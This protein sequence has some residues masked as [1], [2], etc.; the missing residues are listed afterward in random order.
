MSEIIINIMLYIT[1]LIVMYTVKQYRHFCLSL[2]IFNSAQ[3]LSLIRERE[4]C[5]RWS[6][7]VLLTVH[8]G[9]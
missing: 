4:V 9:H 1:L 7:N 5:E 8:F 2:D 3:E 6:S